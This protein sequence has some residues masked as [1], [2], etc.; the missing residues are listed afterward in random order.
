[1]DK[2]EINEIVST[3]V[4]KKA[5]LNNDIVQADGNAHGGLVFANGQLS[6]GWKKNLL[7]IYKETCQ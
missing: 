2:I 6:V 5:N 4:I 7:K 3:D 1:M